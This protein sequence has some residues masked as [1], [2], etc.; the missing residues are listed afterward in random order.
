MARQREGSVGEVF[1]V[2]LLLGLTSFGG[3]IAHLGY[4]R[5][6]YVER[7]RWLSDATYADLVALS[8]FLPG[9]ASSQVGIGVG[10]LRAGYGGAVAAWLAFTLPS[11]V[12]L[13]AFAFLAAGADVA[14]SGWIHGLKLAAVAIVATAVLSMWRNLAPD[15]PRGLLALVAAAVILAI[16]SPFAQLA[17]IAGGGLIGWAFLRVPAPVEIDESPSPVGRRTAGMAL[18]LFIGLLAGLPIAA[19]VT[20]LTGLAVVESFYRAGSL[21][22]GGGHVVLPL[23]NEAVVG[24][25]WVDPDQF[26]AGY[27]AAQAIPGPLFT[28][29]AFL[30]ASL[31]PEPNGL[32]GAAIAVGAIFL[33]SFLLVIGVFPF[34]HRLRASPTFRNALAGTNAAVVGLLLAALYDPVATSAVTSLVDVALVVAALGVLILRD[35]PPW[36]VVAA[37]AAAAQLTAA[38]GVG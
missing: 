24:P 38:A 31:R 6:E 17:V 23:L 9:P 4:F 29:A 18:A 12:L 7:R 1:R 13:T 5:R 22:F 36:L 27:G 15:L 30:G 26:L 3:P 19:A 28:F 16:H 25:G 32:A 37:L 33:P 8:Q 11:A 21:V 20:G 34:W 2:A 10:L 14:D 35:A